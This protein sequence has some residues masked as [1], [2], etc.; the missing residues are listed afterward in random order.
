M[1]TNW[2]TTFPALSLLVDKNRVS[3]LTSY[4]AEG[5]STFLLKINLAVTKARY[6][7]LAPVSTNLGLYLQSPL[8]EMATFLI[9]SP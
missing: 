2:A 1:M 5:I 8:N 4:L 3:Q 7:V 9:Q 6:R